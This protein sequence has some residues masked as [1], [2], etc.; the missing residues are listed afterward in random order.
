MYMHTDGT[1]PTSMRGLYLSVFDTAFAGTCLL[2]QLLDPEQSM[3]RLIERG[4]LGRNPRV[5]RMID[6]ARA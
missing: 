1:L 2:A 5:S 6:G 3:K 4:Q